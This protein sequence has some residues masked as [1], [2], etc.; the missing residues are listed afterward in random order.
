VNPLLSIILHYRYYYSYQFSNVQAS[1]VI[2]DHYHK[3]ASSQT[4]L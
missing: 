2:D 4:V 3:G 1:G